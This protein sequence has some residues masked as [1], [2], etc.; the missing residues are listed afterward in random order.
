MRQNPFHKSVGE[1]SPIIWMTVVCLML[2]FMISI[3]FASKPGSVDPDQGL[4]LI[5]GEKVQ[6]ELK[7]LRDEVAS[8]RSQNSKLQ[9]STTK[10]SDR[11]KMLSESLTK[12]K[13]DSGLTPVEG[14][15][16]TIILRDGDPKKIDTTGGIMNDYVI[17]DM[18]ILKVVNELW[19]SDANAVSVNGNRVALGSNFRCAGTTILVDSIK[20]A[21]PITIQ[22]IGD[23]KK[24]MSSMSMPGGPIEELRNT[25]PTMVTMEETKL[26]KLEPF[27]GAVQ[28]KFMKAIKETEK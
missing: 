28:R 18:D 27:S 17:H 3:T 23:P 20:V 7:S 1:S 2:G 13:V 25:D 22:A 12:L 15:G 16:I 24:L 26:M 4:R 9:E 11:E 6:A 14:P 21:T 10:E 19:N 8:L 5:G